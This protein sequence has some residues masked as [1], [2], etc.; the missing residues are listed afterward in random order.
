M[1]T[2]AGS[3]PAPISA[4]KSV[5]DASAVR[6]PWTVWACVSASILIAIGL[7]WDISWHETIG[8][9]SFWTPAHLLIQLGGLLTGLVCAITIFGATFQ[10]NGTARTSSVNVLGFRGPLGAFIAAWGGLAMV[11]SAPFDNWWHAAYGGGDEP[12][13]RCSAHPAAA[14]LSA[15]GR[16]RHRALDDPAS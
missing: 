2:S 7:Y 6:V 9:D 10:P 8:R 15:A 12:R 11:T 16:I 4:S 1:N 14:T 3:F 5:T 13:G